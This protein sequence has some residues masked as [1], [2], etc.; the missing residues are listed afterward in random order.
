MAA[1]V[2]TLPV[3]PHRQ[4]PPTVLK[5]Q[6]PTLYL[7]GR[8]RLICCSRPRSKQNHSALPGS[9]DGKYKLIKLSGLTA[10]CAIDP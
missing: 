5:S 1:S 6:Q 10:P 2:P 8:R 3:G 7:G 9:Y 4:P